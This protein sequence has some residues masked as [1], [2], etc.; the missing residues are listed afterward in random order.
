MISPTLWLLG[1]IFIGVFVV[2]FAR[3]LRVLLLPDDTRAN[4]ALCKDR[5][6][7]LDYKVEDVMRELREVR[8]LL[9]RGRLA[10]PGKAVAPEQGITANPDLKP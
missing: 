2:S 9:E 6:R 5:L 10:E 8:M 7:D 1:L 4:V 3:L